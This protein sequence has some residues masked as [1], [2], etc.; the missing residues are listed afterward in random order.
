MLKKSKSTFKSKRVSQNSGKRFWRNLLKGFIGWSKDGVGTLVLQKTGETSSSNCSLNE[1]ERMAS[2]GLCTIF[3]LHTP[4]PANS[5]NNNRRSTRRVSRSSS[6]SI[7]EL[8]LL[9]MA[10]MTLSTTCTIPLVACW[11]VFTSLAQ[12]TVT[13]CNETYDW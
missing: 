12:F 9:V 2:N 5:L 4:E 13:T 10:V 8:T 6:V 7:K 3:I 11:S 1:K